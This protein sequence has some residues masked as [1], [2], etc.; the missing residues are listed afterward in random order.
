MAITYTWSIESMANYP[1]AQG[2]SNVVFQV[3]WILT[4]TDG[5]YSASEKGGLA[6]T[7]V[8][9]EPYTPYAQLT[10]QQV[11]GWVTSGIN[12]AALELYQANIASSIENQAN[13]PFVISPLPWSTQ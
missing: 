2:Q 9:G 8:A 13:P 4:G 11:I 6:V 1:A 7:Y 10:E 12:Q 5:T 3:N